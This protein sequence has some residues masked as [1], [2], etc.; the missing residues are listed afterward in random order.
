MGPLCPL[1]SGP[2]APWAQGLFGPLGLG[3]GGWRNLIHMGFGPCLTHSL[4]LGAA[5]TL[6]PNQANP[7]QVKLKRMPGI[8]NH[9][10][11][12]DDLATPWTI[13]PW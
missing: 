6:N 2:W 5:P 13:C 8:Q 9:P 7:S 1:F 4:A 12:L 3:G 10:P 11:T